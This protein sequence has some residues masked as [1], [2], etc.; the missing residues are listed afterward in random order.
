MTEKPG[1]TNPK[2][3]IKRFITI[4]SF[5]AVT[6]WAIIA[7]YTSLF[8]FIALHDDEGYLMITVKQFLDGHVLFNEIFTQYG[9]SYYIYKWILH[10][11]TGLP[12]THDVNRLTALAVWILT[13]F[14]C[15]VF[16]YRLSR[17]TIASLAV[18][19]LTFLGLY[20]TIYEPEHPQSLC[21]FLVAL[22]LILLTGKNSGRNLEIR[23]GILGA[24]L[25]FLFFA[26]INIGV[27]FGLAI[28]FVFVLFFQ[29]GKFRSIAIWV[30][31]AGAIFLPFVLFRKHFF[32]GWIY[33]C[34]AVAFSILAALKSLKKDD[35]AIFSPKHLFISG[36]A[37]AVTSLTIILFVVAKGTTFDALL[38]GVI[39]QNVKFGEAFYYSA[40]VHSY[41]VVL[42]LIGLASAFIYQFF[43]EKTS[44]EKLNLLIALSKIGFGIFIVAVSLFGGKDR[45]YHM[46]I[47]F[48][49]PFLWL[50]L[51]PPMRNFGN[52]LMPRA[53]L[54]L[55]SILLSLQIYPIP[56]SQMSFGSFSM[57]IVAVLCLS[58]GSEFLK[59]SAFFKEKNIP[60]TKAAAAFSIFCILAVCFY[61]GF[62]FYKTFQSQTPL[63]LPGAKR[64][65]LPEKEVSMHQ[66]IVK[67]LVANCDEFI[68]LPGKASYYFWS[69]KQ[70]PTTYNT[71]AWM[72]LLNDRQQQSIVDKLQ[73]SAGSCAVY[74]P[75][76][77]ADGLRG[78]TL[79]SLVLSGYILKNFRT[80]GEAFEHQFM[81]PQASSRDLVYY[82][83]M[84]EKQ[85]G[86]SPAKNSEI[87]ISVPFGAEI[88]RIQIYDLID[89]RPVA[90]SI[91][92]SILD[93]NGQFLKFPLSNQS[94][95]YEVEN[96]KI[97]VDQTALKSEN[98]VLRLFN[99]KGERIATIP[100]V[101]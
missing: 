66:F 73:N 87:K 101:K 46:L 33:F 9:P 30:L 28:A 80:I 64:F 52:S 6:V 95:D 62:T 5:T 72:T 23:L 18:Y 99:S 39:F 100:F 8:G 53:A 98:L 84:I 15:A 48:G 82:A 32:I 77:A 36:A 12:V 47:N 11:L 37:F 13:A 38:N 24:S 42:G 50:L 69:E 61:T 19:V 96:F 21:G 78:Q 44:N 93:V 3:P 91:D 83:K 35:S 79:E 68:I 60:F 70:P 51:I 89:Q 43:R 56:G 76:L 25:A 71:T 20:R 27:F 31:T 81:I 49:I 34:F 97:L 74:Y 40:P 63:D 65:R 7:G 14:I 75:R 10:G 22:G 2:S 67:N 94:G 1:A 57:L 54:V 58:D 90:D 88:S 55:T 41:T 92:N 4:S 17:S 26:K 85:S 86:N 16:A 59:E 29:T 45:R